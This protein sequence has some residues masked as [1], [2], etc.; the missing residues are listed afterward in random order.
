MHFHVYIA[1]TESNQKRK[2]WKK[3]NLLIKVKYIWFYC[4]SP[5]ALYVAI[6]CFC[7][8]F[9]RWND[10]R[11]CEVSPFIFMSSKNDKHW[12]IFCAINFIEIAIHLLL[13]FIQFIH[14]FIHW[15]LFF[16]FN[17]FFIFGLYFFFL[18]IYYF[19]LLMSLF[20]RQF[21]FYFSFFIM[22]SQTVKLQM[23]IR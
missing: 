8:Y 20:E 22:L 18:H 10:F 21:F 5:V 16:F 9:W 17:F 2:E 23:K 7:F 12:T 14:S 4:K 13:Y 3:R 11:I 6:L 15:L 1:F 19:F